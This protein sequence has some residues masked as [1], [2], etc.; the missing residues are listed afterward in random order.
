ME[1]LKLAVSLFWPLALAILVVSVLTERS[2]VRELRAIRRHR[3]HLAQ[4]QTLLIHLTRTEK[5]TMDKFDGLLAEVAA[6]T[7]VTKSA[8]ALIDNLSDQLDEAKDDPEQIAGIVETLRE[9][10]Q[11]LADAII[12]N[13]PA[14]DA[15]ADSGDTEGSAGE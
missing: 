11:A 4:L 6:L 8:I 2:N 9:N 10:R 1:I 5:N 7:N 12:A 14:A 15:D 13:T 3:V